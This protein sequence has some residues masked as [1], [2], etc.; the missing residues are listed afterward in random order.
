MLIKI[1]IFVINDDSVM[2]EPGD[3]RTK[4]KDNV[5]K[6]VC[7]YTARRAKKLCTKKMLFRRLP[8]LG[9]LPKY[10]GDDALGD[11]VAGITV[12]LTVIPQS[13]AYSNVAGLPP[14]VIVQILIYI[15]KKIDLISD[16]LITKNNFLALKFLLLN[17]INFILYLVKIT[18][19][20][21]VNLQNFFSMD[22]T[23]VSWEHLFIYFSD[24][25][26]RYRL[27]PVR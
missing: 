2:D 15:H 10:N 20:P 9:W 23:E 18:Q 1:I 11:I 12:G 6:S 3:D 5:L 16:D 27:D 21:I 8:I 22:Y 19:I 26:K 25:A 7:E 4:R 14:Q 13:L 24:L 17:Q